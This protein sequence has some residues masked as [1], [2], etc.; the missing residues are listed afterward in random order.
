MRTAT[1]LMGQTQTHTHSSVAQ[2]LRCAIVVGTLINRDQ[3]QYRL[4]CAPPSLDPSRG[5]ACP[6]SARRP[7][8]LL[9]TPLSSLRYAYL[10][11][12]WIHGFVSEKAMYPMLEEQMPDVVGIGTREA[13]SQL[14]AAERAYTGSSAGLLLWPYA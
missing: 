2:T 7:P 1:W 13:L 12:L 6:H 3:Y 11:D 5:H 4:E 8:H 9:L 14:P 10:D